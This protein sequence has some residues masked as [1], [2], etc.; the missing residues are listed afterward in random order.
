MRIYTQNVN[1]NIMATIL[2]LIFF[3]AKKSIKKMQIRARI[4]QQGKLKHAQHKFDF[5]VVGFS[6]A[7][8][9]YDNN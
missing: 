8:H 9:A 2:K 3:I 5:V 1:V 4:L 7:T 6:Y